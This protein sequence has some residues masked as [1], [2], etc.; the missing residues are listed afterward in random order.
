[1]KELIRGRGEKKGGFIPTNEVLLSVSRQLNETVFLQ[2]Y[3]NVGPSDE[4]KGGTDFTKLN[5]EGPQVIFSVCVGTNSVFY[6]NK[7]QLENEEKWIY[8]F[9]PNND[10]HS[11][12]E[13]RLVIEAFITNDPKPD[14]IVDVSQAKHDLAMKAPTSQESK[15]LIDYRKNP[16]R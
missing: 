10:I 15:I 3:Y 5:K 2:E 4:I 7:S 16:K 6:L 9:R 1:M 11:I 13:L 8:K 14:E 12:D